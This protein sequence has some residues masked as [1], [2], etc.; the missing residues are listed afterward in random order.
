M[1]K[2][3]LEV[4]VRT[5]KVMPQV[6]KYGIHMTVRRCSEQPVIAAKEVHLYKILQFDLKW[7]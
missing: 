1:E 6:I 5:A 3:Y 4:A 2:K 7:N